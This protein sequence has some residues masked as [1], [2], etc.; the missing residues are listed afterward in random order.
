MEFAGVLEYL[1]TKW[2]NIAWIIILWFLGEIVLR[3]VVNKIVRHAHDDNHEH[4]SQKEK[5][6]KTLGQV[7][8]SAGSVA[9]FLIMLLMVLDLFMVDITPI[10]AGAGVV[11][12]AIGF[13]S[14][15][16]VKDLM[17]GLF[18][19][20]EHRYSLG[21]EVTIDKFK[22]VVVKTTMRSTVLKNEEGDVFYISN[23]NIVKVQNHSQGEQYPE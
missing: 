19:L 20:I 1:S 2:I 12:L 23:G 21:D 15:T 7:L 10:L 5:Q 11:G 8:V 14:Q 17:S 13:G 18:I 9:I 6:A 16:L 22:G 4:D 3:V